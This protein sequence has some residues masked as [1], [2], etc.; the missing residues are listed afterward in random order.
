MSRFTGALAA[1]ALAASALATVFPWQPGLDSLHD[2]SV[3]YLI[4]KGPGKVSAGLPGIDK[5]KIMHFA[6][7]P[8]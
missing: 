7:D 2:D 3:S 5:E 1:V 6:P 8:K 4:G